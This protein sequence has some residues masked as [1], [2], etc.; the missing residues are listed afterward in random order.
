MARPGDYELRFSPMVMQRDSLAPAALALRVRKCIAGESNL[1]ALAPGAGG[2]GALAPCARC[3]Q[4]TVSLDP[5]AAGGCNV[6]GGGGNANCTG[7]VVLPDS[8]HWHSHPRSPLVLRCLAADACAH[9]D[10]RE[11]MA[12]WAADR[13]G[14][15]VEELEPLY[16]EYVA[17]QC[18]EGHE[19]SGFAYPGGGLR[20]VPGTAGRRDKV[21]DGGRP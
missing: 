3:R 16:R 15:S 19:A 8:G 18:A 20:R 21:G 12:R 6:Y 1:T 17:M 14:L 5:L 9:D 13:A 11:A 4:G 2:E 10:A 7:V